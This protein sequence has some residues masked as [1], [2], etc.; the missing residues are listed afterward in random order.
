MEKDRFV[1]FVIPAFNAAKFLEKCVGSITQN[2]G[3]HAYEILIVDNNSKDETAAIARQL[4]NENIHLLS[5]ANAGVSHARNMGIK[6]AKGKFIM[7]SDAD[8]FVDANLEKALDLASA[9]PEVDIFQFNYVR[10]ERSAS[11]QIVVTPKKIQNRIIQE[12][13]SDFD[14]F[15]KNGMTNSL[16][17]KFFRREFLEEKGLVMKQFSNAED[18]EFVSRAFSVAQKIFASDVSFYHYIIHEN[19]AMTNQRISKLID[20]IEACKEA[21]V[22]LE[23]C[24]DC[25]RK[26]LIHSFIS[27]TAYFTLTRYSLLPITERSEFEE[28]VRKNINVFLRPTTLT[29]RL[30]WYFFKIFGTKFTLRTIAALRRG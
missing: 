19:S 5:C 16:W 1:S 21:F 15:L 9:N 22:N 2:V 23:K 26:N 7:F 24:A 18:M 28:Y 30:V 20:A 4:E 17:S 12:S 8:D 25:Q 13:S 3:K 29:N 11:K 14:N 10:E 27:R 6:N